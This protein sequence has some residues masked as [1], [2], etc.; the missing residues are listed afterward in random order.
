MNKMSYIRT[1][2]FFIDKVTGEI[3]QYPVA[4]NQ[5]L[6]PSAYMHT[7]SASAAAVLIYLQFVRIDVTLR[8]VY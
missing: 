8:F 5:S 7:Y 2:R 3:S 4:D 6:F 1:M